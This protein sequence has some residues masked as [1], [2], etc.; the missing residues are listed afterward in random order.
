[1]KNIVY[2]QLN[3][4]EVAERGWTQ[5]KWLKAAEAAKDSGSG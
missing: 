4:V 2:S 1:M 3:M 5:Q